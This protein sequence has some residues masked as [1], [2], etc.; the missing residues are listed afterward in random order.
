MGA[1]ML[2]SGMVEI[3]CLRLAWW[4]GG[5]RGGDWRGDRHGVFFFFFFFFFFF[6]VVVVASVWVWL[7]CGFWVWW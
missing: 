4:R 2:A 1:V 5:R 7:L 6:V 3:V